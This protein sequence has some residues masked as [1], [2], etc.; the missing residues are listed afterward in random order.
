[1]FMDEKRKAIIDQLDDTH[2]K[3]VEAFEK[4][5]DAY[6]NDPRSVLGSDRER[7]GKF[8]DLLKRGWKAWEQ[9]GPCMYRG[10]GK[11]SIRRSHTIHKSGPLAQIAE[12]QHVLTPTADHRGRLNMA[13][14]GVKVAIS[15]QQN[16]PL[17]ID[18]T[19]ITGLFN[20]HLEFARDNHRQTPKIP[21]NRPR[22]VPRSLRR[23]RKNW[24]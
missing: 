19:G 17:V 10:C 20:A 15:F 3:I 22:R 2:K 13:R 9:S 14:I 23:Y 4:A 1:M 7:A 18:K 12:A 8:F 5:D 6:R 11:I 24:G 16:G 21:R